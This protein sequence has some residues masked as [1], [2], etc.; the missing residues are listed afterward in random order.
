MVLGRC[1]DC[2]ETAL[3]CNYVVLASQLRGVAT[4]MIV[5]KCQ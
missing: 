3:T 5:C 2:V 1:W 4:N